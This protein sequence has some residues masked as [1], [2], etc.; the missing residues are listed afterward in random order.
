MFE[1]NNFLDVSVLERPQVDLLLD[2]P[3][4][5][6]AALGADRAGALDAVAAELM[7]KNRAQ[8]Q[9]L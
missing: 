3:P 9:L 5:Q 6:V 1:K 2:V 7:K 8:L 4:P